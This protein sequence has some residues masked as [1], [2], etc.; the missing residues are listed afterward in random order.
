L[1]KNFD[2]IKVAPVFLQIV[3]QLTEK[4]TYF[5]CFSRIGRCS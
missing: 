4:F 5:T 2:Y 1:F 3:T